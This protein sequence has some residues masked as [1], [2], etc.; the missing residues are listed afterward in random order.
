M[1][2]HD[3][4]APRPDRVSHRRHGRVAAVRP[5]GDERRQ[6]SRGAEARMSRR[7]CRG[8]RG[9]RRVVEQHATAAVHLGVDKPRRQGA[10]TEVLARQVGRQRGFRHET[11]DPFPVDHDRMVIEKGLAVEDPGAPQRFGRHQSVSV[12]LRRWLGRSGSWPRARAS[13]SA[14]T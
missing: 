10:A 4:G 6:E 13:V 12:T 5:V 2:P 3:A 8:S 1:E 14:K 11:D 9:R 7:D